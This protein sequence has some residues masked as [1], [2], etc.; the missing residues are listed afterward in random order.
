M[1]L[2]SSSSVATFIAES[3]IL[4]SVA[5]DRYVAICD[6]LPCDTVLS[7][8]AAVRIGLAVVLRSFCGILSYAFLV[9]RL[10]FCHSNVLPHNYCEHMAVAKFARADVGADVW[11][12]LSVLLSTLG[13]LPCS[14]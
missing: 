2:R 6:P 1:L 4:L 5:F 11:Y 14:S 9:K 7:H 8:M 3:G 12:G 13:L 10:L